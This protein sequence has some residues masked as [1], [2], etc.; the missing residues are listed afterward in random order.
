METFNSALTD[1]HSLDAGKVWCFHLECIRQ[2][3]GLKRRLVATAQAKS[4]TIAFTK[5]VRWRSWL[6]SHWNRNDSATWL[7]TSTS[8]TQTDARDLIESAPVSIYKR[9]TWNAGDARGILM[10]AAAIYD[11]DRPDVIAYMT[12]GCSPVGVSAVHEFVSTHASDRC[13]MHISI[14]A[15]SD[16][17][18]V[19]NWICPNLATCIS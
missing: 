6:H 1:T 11:A 5:P 2:L 12:A 16:S 10:A 18:P 8:L 14:P 4:K 13:I 15:Y 7:A 3:D 9:L 19:P 17:D